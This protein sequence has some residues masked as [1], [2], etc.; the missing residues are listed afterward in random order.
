[1]P[2][3]RFPCVS[4]SRPVKSNQKGFQCNSCHKWVHFKC[5]DLTISQYN[6]LAK[7]EDLPFY[8]LECKPRPRYADTLFEN[9]I[10][11][12]TTTPSSSMNSG[13]R[14]T[15][16][17]ESTPTA[18]SHNDNSFNTY[19]S[20]LDSSVD[21][22]DAHSSDFDI[23]STDESDNDLR[24]LNFASLP[25]QFY[26]RKLNL[27][28][29]KQSS[30]LNTKLPSIRYKYQCGVCCGPCRENVQDSIQCTLCDDWVHQ[31]CSNL[32]YEKFLEYCN[33]INIDKPYF[34]DWC[35]FGSPRS[36]LNQTCLS[37]SAISSFDSS[38]IFDMCPNSIF[39]DKEDV[40]TT[41]Y[42]TT[43]ELNVEIQK[44]SR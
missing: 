24:G 39:R 28:H 19:N 11:T 29:T 21:F 44:N 5:M 27:N 15:T 26:Q 41:E 38:D 17:I 37:A 36:T 40:P 10:I 18:L 16:F 42:Y 30:T 8:C 35:E 13:I 14:N 31:K 34:C 32:S 9:T 1:M 12:A 43:D 2:N 33:P 3:Y 7:N 23:V 6:F 4:C 22:S 20:S 25:T